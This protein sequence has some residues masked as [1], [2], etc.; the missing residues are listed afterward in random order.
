[1]ATAEV[2]NG[3]VS[4][5]RIWAL[6][7]ELR[8]LKA[9]MADMQGRLDSLLIE[10]GA[11]LRQSIAD[12]DVVAETLPEQQ[13]DAQL[14]EIVETLPQLVVASEEAPSQAPTEIEPFAEIEQAAPIADEPVQT[15]VV[16]GPAVVESIEP[17]AQIETIEM[18]ETVVATDDASLVAAAPAIEIA[19]VVALAETVAEV[20]VAET[21]VTGIV[22]ETIVEIPAAVSE[23]VAEP[24]AVE[25]QA[26]E[27][28]AIVVEMPANVVVLAERRPAPRKARSA[29]V[30][31]G[32]WAAVITLIAIFAAAAATGTGFAGNGELIAATKVCAFAGE[33]CSIMMGIP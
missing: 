29:V 27:T 19:E 33:L 11:E 13:D 1:M 3:S 22:A 32:R 8:L 26:T 4:R 2:G 14:T 25:A 12:G 9:G 10:I 31:A 7:S 16:E 18:A 6:A 15:D 30:R 5:T 24:I 28:P 17:A 23:I 21:P 20:P